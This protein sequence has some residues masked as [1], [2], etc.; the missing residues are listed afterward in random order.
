MDGWVKVGEYGTHWMA[1]RENLRAPGRA[2]YWLS[3]CGKYW[4]PAQPIITAEA[5]AKCPDCAA[6]M[7][8]TTP[9]PSPQSGEGPRGRQKSEGRNQNSEAEANTTSPLPS[10]QSGEGK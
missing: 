8:G 6:R 1:E 5:E 7:N 3:L 4:A 2:T 9:L 10:S